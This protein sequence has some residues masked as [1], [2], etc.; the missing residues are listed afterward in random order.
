MNSGTLKNLVVKAFSERGLSSSA[1]LTESVLG[2]EPRILQE[3]LSQRPTWQGLSPEFLDKCPGG[4]GSALSFLSS[5]AFAYYLP[6]F[7][8]ADVDG[9]LGRVDPLFHL[10]NG[11]D[12][13]SKDERVN[14]IMYGDKTWFSEKSQKFSVFLVGEVL[15]II[16][17]LQ[18]RARDDSFDEQKAEQAIKNYWAP[19]LDELKGG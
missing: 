6:A 10:T 4:Y 8:L 1:P 12:D 19:R 15:A 16:E 9:L 13:A 17:Y 7:I 18:Y 5:A 11:L 14:S 3:E 2:E